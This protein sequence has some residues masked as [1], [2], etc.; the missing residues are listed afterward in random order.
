M[1]NLRE[2]EFNTDG[3]EH[4]VLLLLQRLWTLRRLKLSNL[5]GC[6]YLW[7]CWLRWRGLVDGWPRYAVQAQLLLQLT[8]LLGYGGL[9]LG[10]HSERLAQ[11]HDFELELLK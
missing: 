7:W 8:V 6:G 1:R 2:N 4:I 5:H 10:D 11:A 3:I 9:L